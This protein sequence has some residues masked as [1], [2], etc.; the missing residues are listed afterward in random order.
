[1]LSP[2]AAQ[3]GFVHR[4]TAFLG[5]G[6]LVVALA[7]CTGGAAGPAVPTA[8]PPSGGSLP[9]STAGSGASPGA[10]LDPDAAVLAY[11]K[12]M[13]DHGVDMPDPQFTGSGAG[14]A[15]SGGAVSGEP[16]SAAIQVSGDPLSPAFK[17]ASAACDHLLPRI[18]TNEG[19]Q[20][21]QE[22][23]DQALKTAR[24]MRDHGIDMPDP[25]FGTGGSVTID[26]G[27]DG[28]DPSSQVF[29]DAAKACGMGDGATIT[30][31]GGPAAPS[32]KP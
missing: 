7:A 27:G 1:M 12:C 16:G 13:R 25:Q 21:S 28:I 20:V 30:V 29:K 2:S 8:P 6:A 26:V 15:L 11:T 4:L 5:A 19:G 31:G 32:A 23:I 9:T 24:C 22:F 3:P 10:S 18:G 14:G 17:D